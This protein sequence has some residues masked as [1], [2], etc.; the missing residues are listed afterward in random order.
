MLKEDDLS[1]AENI[2]AMT[3]KAARIL[4]GTYVLGGPRFLSESNIRRIYTR[5]DEL[6]RRQKANQ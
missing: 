6:Y 4:L 1:E 5:P 3:V 2:T